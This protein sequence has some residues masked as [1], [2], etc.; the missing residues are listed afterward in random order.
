MNNQIHKW[1]DV[2]GEGFYFIRVPRR[3]AKYI[4]I[5]LVLA[6]IGVIVKLIWLTK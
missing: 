6:I 5:A 3:R 1:S 4:E 2:A